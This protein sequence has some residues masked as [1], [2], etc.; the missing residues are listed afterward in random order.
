LASLVRPCRLAEAPLRGEGGQQAGRQQSLPKSMCGGPESK[1]GR[2]TGCLRVF[3]RPLLPVQIRPSPH[4]QRQRQSPKVVQ[5]ACAKEYYEARRE[6]GGLR[7]HRSRMEVMPPLPF[8]LVQRR[9]QGSKSVGKQAHQRQ[10]RT[11]GQIHRAVE[12]PC[13][14]CGGFLVRLCD[15]VGAPRG[16]T[17]LFFRLPGWPWCAPG[18]GAAASKQVGWSGEA[19]GSRGGAPGGPALTFAPGRAAGGVFC[20][21]GSLGDKWLDRTGAGVRPSWARKI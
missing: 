14:R 20:Q 19:R 12:A 15:L 6:P 16:R 18:G 8:R 5:D 13:R 21:G 10:Q 3:R 17:G 9:R 7:R 1:P 4:T 2:W 11:K